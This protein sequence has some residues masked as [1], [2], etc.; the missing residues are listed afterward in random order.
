V[1]SQLETFAYR[2]EQQ[3]RPAAAKLRSHIAMSLVPFP[4]TT[5]VEQGGSNALS[6]ADGAPSGWVQ[7]L[8]E[9]E[10]RNRVR[11]EEKS[12]RMREWEEMKGLRRRASEDKGSMRA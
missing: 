11:R 9:E 2:I 4:T 5:K 12:R 7:W 10:E 6:S 3:L 1:N 8:E